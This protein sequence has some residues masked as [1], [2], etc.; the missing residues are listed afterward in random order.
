LSAGRD[1]TAIPPR[2]ENA[3]PHL[4]YGGMKLCYCYV[5][6]FFYI[7]CV[8]IAI[9]DNFVLVLS[10]GSPSQALCCYYATPLG[11]IQKQLGAITAKVE[12]LFSWESTH[13]KHTQND[14]E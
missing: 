2:R 5:P 6:V 3:F 12:C 7:T 9:C 14:N 13:I 4:G 11:V 10:C 1:P 8:S